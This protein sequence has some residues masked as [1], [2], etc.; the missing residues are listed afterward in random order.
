MK[1]GKGGKSATD[2]KVDGTVGNDNMQVGF[3]DFQGDQIT[4]LADLIYAYGGDDTVFAGHGDDVIYGDSGTLPEQTGKS[5]KSGKSGKGGKGAPI[6]NIPGDDELH[7]GSGNDRIFGE[8]GDDELYGDAGNDTLFGGI[9]N[10][11]IDGGSGADQ[12]SGGFGNDRFVNVTSGDVVVG[13][14]DPD[15]LD[16]DVLDLTGTGVH[17]VD[18]TPGDPEAGIVTFID[19]ST[20]TFSEI[21]N[22]I[23][24]FTPGTQIATPKGTV[25]VENLREGD[26][27]I[28]RDNGIQE[29]RWVGQK[30]M[31]AAKLDASPNLQPILIREGALGDGLPERDMWVSPQHRMLLTSARAMFYFGEPEIFVPAKHLLSKPGINRAQGGEVQY[32]HFMFDHHQ[33]VLSDGTWTESFQ[34]GDMSLAGLDSE[35]RS[36]LL[37]VFPE[38]GRKG[39]LYPAARQTLKSFEANLIV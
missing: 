6:E 13:G 28:T 35:A 2:G 16:V 27:V 4:D 39:T 11:T 34:P 5:G 1:S 12:Q 14:E 10:D 32:I 22:V 37:E 36:E 33:V 18:Y 20:M 31:S 21:E 3:T 19:G 30:T 25:S 9:G 29:I 38:L 7:G 8:Q 26:K 23:P 17:R 15:D 24:C